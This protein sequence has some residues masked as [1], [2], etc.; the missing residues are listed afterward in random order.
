MKRAIIAA[1][2][3]TL[4]ETLVAVAGA[5]FADGDGGTAISI[6]SQARELISTAKYAEAEEL[7]RNSAEA[8]KE[9]DR[10]SA[11]YAATL[12]LLGVL[13]TTLAKYSQADACLLE[14]ADI[15]QRLPKKGGVRYAVVLAH[16]A[17]ALEIRADFAEAE[18]LINESLSLLKEAKLDQ[19]VA[20]AAALT[21]RADL[22]WQK[23]KFA[24]AR[25]TYTRAV[26]LFK[27]NDALET[28]ACATAQ[29][30][31][32]RLNRSFAPA[33]AEGLI[34]A[35]KDI[36]R[37]LF[38][39]Q[40]PEFGGSLVTQAMFSQSQGKTAEAE[41]LLQQAQEIYK[42]TLGEDHPDYAIVVNALA[43]AYRDGRNYLEAET[44]ARRAVKL[45][46][47]V[48][49]PR[50]PSYAAAWNNLALVQM[51][52]ANYVDAER[53][54][55]KAVG[56]Y[57][58]IF[59]RGHPQRLIVR[60]NLANLYEAEG[61]HRWAVQILEQERDARQTS[62]TADPIGYARWLVAVIRIQGKLP[63][64]NAAERQTALADSIT[65]LDKALAPLR[66]IR[67]ADLECATLLEELARLNTAM[68]A[69][70][71][72]DAV[73][74]D[75][76]KNSREI[77]P[78]GKGSTSLSPRT[79]DRN[80]LRADELLKEALKI[81][82]AY[83]GENHPDYA[84]A[85]ESQAGL[86]QKEAAVYP[87]QASA[88]YRAAESNYGRVCKI[89]EQWLGRQHPDYAA[90]LAN[91]AGLYR[92]QRKDEDAAPKYKQAL[93]II[94]DHLNK[95][96]TSQS[97]QQ[98]LEMT[99]MSRLYL[100]EYLS[101]L[102]ASSAAADE[103]YAEVLPWK[104]AVSRRQQ[105]IRGIRGALEEKNPD[106]EKVYQDLE[107]A[108]RK[109]AQLSHA[110]L[111]PAEEMAHIRE[112]DELGATIERLQSDLGSRSEDFRREIES[113]SRTPDEIRQALPSN[114]ALID[115]LEYWHFPKVAASGQAM[116]PA[117]RLVA[118]IVSRRQPTK[119]VDLGSATKIE[120][121]VESWLKVCYQDKRIPKEPGAQLRRLLW[122]PMESH[123]ADAE[124]VLISPDGATAWLPW[125]ALPAKEP[126][127]FLIESQSLAMLAVPQ[128][129][130]DI[131][132]SACDPR[133]EPP[134]LLVVGDI[135]YGAAPGKGDFASR[136]RSAVRG[137]SENVRFGWRRL[138][139][140]KAEVLQVADSFSTA[141]PN[142]PAL[143]LRGE[144]P[145]EET[146]RAESPKNRYLH[147][148]THGFFAPR[149]V[150]S[151]SRKTDAAARG[152]GERAARRDVS[153]FHPGLLS[154][155]VLA[156]ANH[157]KTFDE[158]DGILTALEIEQLD[159]SRVRLVTL[160]ACQTGIGNTSAGEGLLGLQ[161]AFQVA[162]ASSVLASL[163]RVDD[164]QT[165]RLMGSFYEN[166][167][168]K[169]LS[170]A[171]ALRQ[172]QLEILNDEALRGMVFS[173]KQGD[174]QKRVP[175]YYWA[176]FV[177]SGDWR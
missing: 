81:R 88:F 53:A 59:D 163:W 50:H 22:D 142:A 147:F 166:L 100:D 13:Y 75:A 90:A 106:I 5:A 80:Y 19:G 94:Q 104:G 111:Q 167:W 148:A 93:R 144:A 48:L 23:G 72:N 9:T 67:G 55:T 18:R 61:N 99:E 96:A 76:P 27:D 43:N 91:L 60:D 145:T 123:V 143:S 11:D 6:L 121:A 108:S 173:T 58:T 161:R 71:K 64:L 110:E 125:A 105:T 24:D 132:G 114:V 128:M 120:A 153:G 69:L 15:C 66:T 34:A 35:A 160:S 10:S 73:E 170:R 130:P 171:Q 133:N 174:K 98:Q 20:Y 113:R 124:T 2:L 115:L 46:E 164:Q 77:L 79:R 107:K 168:Q 151:T 102:I 70:A 158:D 154:G 28:A 92:A 95:T 8:Q 57:D 152:P 54:F 138:P 126:D 117:R 26:E 131:L 150:V 31:L 12:D 47:K 52:E 33:K 89:R 156:G 176:A 136:T 3:T 86:Y 177:L 56:L 140:S 41:T 134:A 16:R 78:V 30:S 137:D 146:V 135:D 62:A 14:A 4:V 29:N 42:N 44:Q 39:E 36:R 63:T 37:K 32:G 159:L 21:V 149:D 109:L 139:A 49:G 74:K 85:L 116:F 83:R 175:P 127:K 112:L 97:E 38:G 17:K 165:A 162:G 172:A 68:A 119:L 118:F 141:Y 87:K 129:L 169:R 40:H 7:L 122:A 82:K 103:L 25:A 1:L 157:P 101:L 155:I 45:C 65:A 51:L 84:A